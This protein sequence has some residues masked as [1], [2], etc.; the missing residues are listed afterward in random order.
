MISPRTVGLISILKGNL[1]KTKVIISDVNRG[2]T[3]TS[4]KHLCRVCCKGL[5]SNS[6]F[7]N[8]CTHCMHKRSSG[9]NGRLENVLDFKCRICLNL[10]VAKDDNK[11]V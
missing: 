6:I 3:F 10:T 4:G 2:P 7:C 5:G 9:L 1:T 11:K 8:H